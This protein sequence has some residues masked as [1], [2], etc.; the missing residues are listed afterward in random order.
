MLR[1]AIVF[2]IVAL[3]AGLMGFTGIYV[4]MAGIA[5]ILFFFFLAR[6]SKS[7]RH[8]RSALDLGALR[9]DCEVA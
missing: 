5:K 9:P 6:G 8:G 2:F 1:W 3:L 4:A 7:L